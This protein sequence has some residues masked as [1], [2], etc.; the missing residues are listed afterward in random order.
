MDKKK[1]LII[2]VISITVAIFIFMGVTFAKTRE[3]SYATHTNNI[4]NVALSPFQRFFSNIGGGISDFF[5]YLH[6][7]KTYKEDNLEL[8]QE[9]EELL[10]KMHKHRREES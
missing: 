2:V 7:M 10:L 9:V 5:S 1:K 6:D 8:K 3:S 4:V